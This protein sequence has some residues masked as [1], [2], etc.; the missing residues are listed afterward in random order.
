MEMKKLLIAGIAIA[1]ITAALFITPQPTDAD[2]ELI[3]YETAQ[4][5]QHACRLV[6]HYGAADISELGRKT[7][8]AIESH[9]A[10]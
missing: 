2:S 4:E 10:Y 9:N 8:K 5:L 3:G 6:Y 1:L 7:C